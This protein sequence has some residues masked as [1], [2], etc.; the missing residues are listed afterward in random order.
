VVAAA[1]VI[2][3]VVVVAALFSMEGLTS[4]TRGLPLLF[5]ILF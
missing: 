5:E 1:F 2:V 3:Y 4:Y